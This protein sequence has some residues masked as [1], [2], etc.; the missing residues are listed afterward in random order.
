MKKYLAGFV[1]GLV[2]MGTVVPSQATHNN[3]HL[4]RQIIALQEKTQDLDQNGIYRGMVEE[5]QVISWTCTAED[6]VWVERDET[7]G[8]FSFRHL[9][10]PNPRREKRD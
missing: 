6:A 4:R 8:P 7:P 1:T 10:C 2:L 3:R 5:K 9:S